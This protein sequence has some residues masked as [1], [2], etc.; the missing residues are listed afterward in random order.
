[1]APTIDEALEVLEGTGPEYGGGLANHGPMAAEALF[2][3][4]RAEEAIPW[5]STYKRRLRDRPEARNPISGDDWREALG[6]RKRLGDWAAFFD[7]ALADATWQEVLNTWAPR[8]GPGLIAAATHGLIRTGHAV[9]SL[10][11]LET[12]ERRHELAQGLAYWAARYVQLPEAPPN[13][14]GGVRPS[15][16]IDSV[17][18]LPEERRVGGSIL[19]GLLQLDEDFAPAINLVDTSTDVSAFV[20]DLTETFA[21]VYL[22]N[23]HDWLATI[24]FIHSV[25][26]P[27]AARLIAPHLEAKH[28]PPLLRY[29]WQAGAG[30]YAAFGATPAPT[31]V[32]APDGDR[33]DLI[34][35]AVATGDEHAIKF[36]EACLREYDLN[37]KPVYLAAARHAAERLAGKN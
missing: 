17:G 2:A 31:T 21:G 1:M 19:L 32:E 4:G 10:A 37:P 26:G 35:R 18:L 12:P 11:A 25:T 23:A 15:Q 34:D 3:L 8:L 36:A 7:R 22:A 14:N 20:S 30:L 27:S 16:A 13:A 29:A 9:R 33:D 6:D 5:A 28:V 24:V